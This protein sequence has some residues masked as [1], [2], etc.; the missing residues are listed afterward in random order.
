MTTDTITMTIHTER[1]WITIALSTVGSSHLSAYKEL[2]CK[3]L[4]QYIA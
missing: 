4:Q 2:L 3:S 1:P